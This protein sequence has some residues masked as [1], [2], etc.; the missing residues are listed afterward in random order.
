MNERITTPKAERTVQNHALPAYLAMR[1]PVSSA[2]WEESQSQYIPTPM[3]ASFAVYV[4]LR[5]REVG[6]VVVVVVVVVC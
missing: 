2:P 5:A 6:G 3:V 1:R 4:V